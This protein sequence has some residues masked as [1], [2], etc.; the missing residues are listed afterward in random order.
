MKIQ[1][2]YDYSTFISSTHENDKYFIIFNKTWIDELFTSE[3]SEA[4]HPDYF[5]LFH[6]I[7]PQVGY[8]RVTEYMMTLGRVLKYGAIG[9]F[10]MTLFVSI[11]F[12]GQMRHYF[13]FIRTF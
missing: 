9:M 12:G 4:L 6:D 5:Y 1:L 3:K 8:T 7:P 2:Y 10:W 13:T 11:M